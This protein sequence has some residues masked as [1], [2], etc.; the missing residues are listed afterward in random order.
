MKKHLG[1]NPE[2][3]P[4]EDIFGIEIKEEKKQEEK[5]MDVKEMLGEIKDTNKSL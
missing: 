2:Q 1:L 4:K 3:Y 5:Q